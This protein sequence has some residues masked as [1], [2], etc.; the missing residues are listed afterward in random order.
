MKVREHYIM[1]EIGKNEQGRAKRNEERTTDVI[2]KPEIKK[3]G[4]ASAMW[5]ESGR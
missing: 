4:E 1:E 2:M 3:G 5:K